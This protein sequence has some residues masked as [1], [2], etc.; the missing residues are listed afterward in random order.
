MPIRKASF[1]QNEWQR[2]SAGS[3]LTGINLHYVRVNADSSVVPAEA[4]GVFLDAPAMAF[5]QSR[6]FSFGADGGYAHTFVLN[7]YWFATLALMLGIGGNNTR[8]VND[9]IQLSTSS[10]GLHLNSTIRLAAGYNSEKWFAGI[11]YVN[12]LNRNFAP[13]DQGNTI[14]QQT[15]HGLYRLVVARR[16]ALSRN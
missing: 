13:Q 14:W 11:Y 10:F 3:F 15:S 4:N 2:R 7:E 9:D 12:F 16:L 5:S 6:V 1:V 8:L